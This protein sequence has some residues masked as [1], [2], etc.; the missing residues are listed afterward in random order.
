LIAKLSPNVTDI[1]CVAHAAVDAGCDALSLINTLVG[2]AVDVKTRKPKLANVTGGLSGPAIKPVGVAMVHKVARTVKVPI[3]G[4]GG[5]MTA[6]DALEYII[7][8]ASAV[9]IGTG[10]FVDPQIPLKAIKGIKDYC[11]ANRLAS[12]KEIVGSVRACS[13]M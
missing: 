10:V 2:M 13:G 7:V 1:S 12:V 6:E 3:I 5:I 8:G 11:R 9:Q 4:I